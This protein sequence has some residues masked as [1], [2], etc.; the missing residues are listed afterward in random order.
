MAIE[1]DQKARILEQ[2]KAWLDTLDSVDE[3]PDGILPEE[4]LGDAQVPDL[5]SLH[6]AMTALTQEVRLASRATQ[7][8]REEVEAQVQS[9]SDAEE[10][11]RRTARTIESLGSEAL[12][13]VKR[14]GQRELLLRYVDLVDR[15]ERHDQALAAGRPRG[16][17]SGR[18][19][20]RHDAMSKGFA[21][22]FDRVRDD[23]A[24]LGLRSYGVRG[25]RFDPE[26][27]RAVRQESNTGVGDGEVCEV[28]RKGY[29]RDDE[30]VRQCEVVV[31][32]ESD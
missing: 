21:L 5:F 20:V 16:F 22:V 2:V 8:L 6:A 15:L 32:R 29:R 13:E 26:S 18:H 1:T 31:A 23:L 11:E 24:Q 27:M 19:L 3:L 30:I 17:L 9:L 12:T 10:R 14:A 7:K 4:E 25:D 28:L